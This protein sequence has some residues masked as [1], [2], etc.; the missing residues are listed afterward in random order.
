M[1]ELA[2]NSER[3]PLSLKTIAEEHHLSFFFLQKVAH[4]LKKVG[5]IEANRGKLGG[6]VLA[7]D[8]QHISIQEI[9]EAL[10]G[11]IAFMH[12]LA[13]EGVRSHGCVREGHCQMRGGLQFIN[14]LLLK[15]L[16]TTTLHHLLHPSWQVQK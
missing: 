2:K 5:L 9:L 11:P 6:Y 3:E 8:S 14:Q 7:K 4:E 12:C 1:T 16:R 13:P 10:E 15:T